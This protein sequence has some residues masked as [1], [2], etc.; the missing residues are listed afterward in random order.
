M[1]MG[2]RLDERWSFFLTLKLVLKGRKLKTKG[3]MEI[4]IR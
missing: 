4:E 2:K 3:R 1:S